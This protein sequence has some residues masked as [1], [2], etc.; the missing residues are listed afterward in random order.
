MLSVSVDYVTL[1]QAKTGV[2]PSIE[3][4]S[5]LQLLQLAFIHKVM[6][7]QCIAATGTD[8]NISTCY[9]CSHLLLLQVRPKCK[10]N[11]IPGNTMYQC[12]L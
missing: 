9:L 3:L 8:V 6:F 11:T 7:T 2:K 12:C 10:G 1:H 4:F 5:L